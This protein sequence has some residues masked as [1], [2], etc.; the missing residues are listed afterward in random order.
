MNAYDLDCKRILADL[1]DIEEDACYCSDHI[2]PNDNYWNHAGERKTGLPLYF[3]ED[4]E[5]DLPNGFGDYLAQGRE[6]VALTQ[7][8]AANIET[9]R[10]RVE[11]S[12][13]LDE[14]HEDFESDQATTTALRAKFFNFTVNAQKMVNTELHKLIGDDPVVIKPGPE[15]FE[16]SL[17]DVQALKDVEKALTNARAEVGLSQDNSLADLDV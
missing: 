12:V 9:R 1:G 6:G 17:A 8:I 5:H 14:K 7:H 2:F 4:Y 3:G 16:Q 11:H 15:G 13:N 10:I